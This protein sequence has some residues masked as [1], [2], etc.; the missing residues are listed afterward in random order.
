LPPAERKSEGAVGPEVALSNLPE[1]NPFFTGRERV[2]AQLQEAL[3]KQGRAALSGLRGVGKTQTAVEY[4][5]RHF[6]E[7][8]HLFW[9]TA[10]SREALLSSYVTIA[11]LL[12]LPESDAQ[13]Q[14]RAVDAVK[15]WLGSNQGWLLILDNADDIVMARAFLPSGKKGHV[16][17][18]TQAQ[19]AGGTARRVEIQE[20]ETEEGALFLLRRA[21]RIAEDAPLGAAAE[22]DQGEAKAIAE[23][24]DG[25]PLALDQAGAYVEETGCGLQGYLGLYR[26]GAPELLRRRGM[27]A[28]D[29]REVTEPPYISY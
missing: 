8:V 1:R 29:H 9:A 16:I 7:Y 2:L 18:T 13:D 5:H 20:M 14:T 24:L 10:A 23:Q 12:K 25:L 26:N 28:S 22:A 19:A 17:L 27:L 4:A 6:E 11:G 21:T 3:A 15:R